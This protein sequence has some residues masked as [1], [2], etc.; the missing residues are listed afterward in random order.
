MIHQ[1]RNKSNSGAT[2][3][4]DNIYFEMTHAKTYAASVSLRKYYADLDETNLKSFA[5]RMKMVAFSRSF[6][7]QRKKEL[8]SLTCEYCQR[9]HLII[10]FN[11]MKVPNT[12]KATIDH[13]DPTSQG[14]APF[15]PEN[16]NVKPWNYVSPKKAKK[17]I[18]A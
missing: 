7:T 16:I 13:I 14:G 2:I 12:Q 4:C 11:G 15:D 9:P 3:F 1:V 6:L 5:G 8:G 17:L 18:A 10:E